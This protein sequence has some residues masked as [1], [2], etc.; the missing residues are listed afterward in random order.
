M[1]MQALVLILIPAYSAQRWVCNTIK[2]AIAQTWPAL[3][4]GKRSLLPLTVL[5]N[6]TVEV[7]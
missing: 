5:L 7:V 1:D 4:P 2:S 3:A 6:G